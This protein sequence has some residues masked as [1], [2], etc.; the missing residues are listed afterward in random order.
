MG[1]LGFEIPELRTGFLIA[2]GI[3]VVIGI[4]LLALAPTKQS[5]LQS[6]AAGA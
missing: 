3:L 2:S 4:V 1:A 6:S 5:A